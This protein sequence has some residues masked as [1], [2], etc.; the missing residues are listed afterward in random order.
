LPKI[1]VFIVVSP[2]TST[3]L[4]EVTLALRVVKNPQTRA[5]KS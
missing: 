4:A 1:A 5:E 2:V 3:A